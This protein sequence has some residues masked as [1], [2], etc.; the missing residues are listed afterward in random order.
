MM[1]RNKHTDT[2]DMD[3]IMKLEWDVQKTAV[4]I[5]RYGLYI[6]MII[7]INLGRRMMI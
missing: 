2:Q 7:S 4:I 6:G 1:G 3:K 5:E